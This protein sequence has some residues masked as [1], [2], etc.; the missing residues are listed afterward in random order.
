MDQEEIQVSFDDET[1]E[2]IL[3]KP[4]L[5]SPNPAAT[6]KDTRT[7]IITHH[8]LTAQELLDRQIIQNIAQTTTEELQNLHNEELLTC[9]NTLTTIFKRKHNTALPQ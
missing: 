5:P 9:I 1:A 2:F 3:T 4:P 8:P 7:V 6:A